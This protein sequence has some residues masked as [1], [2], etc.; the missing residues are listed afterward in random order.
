MGLLPIP[1]AA[2]P[3]ESQATPLTLEGF[4]SWLMVMILHDFH[5]LTVGE[6]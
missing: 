1:S 3:T 6:T 4:R 5:T 2:P